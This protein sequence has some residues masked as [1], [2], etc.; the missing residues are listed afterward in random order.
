MPK[1]DPQAIEKLLCDNCGLPTNI[2]DYDLCNA[3]HDE[4][5]EQKDECLD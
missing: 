2:D 5:A 4:Q 1:P 3:C